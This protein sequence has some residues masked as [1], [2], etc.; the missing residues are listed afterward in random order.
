VRDDI[1]LALRYSVWK[2]TALVGTP[3]ATWQP[4]R[5]VRAGLEDEAG[6]RLG[7][8]RDVSDPGRE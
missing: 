2:S 4:D 3:V 6:E 5:H 8:D 7:S 1:E